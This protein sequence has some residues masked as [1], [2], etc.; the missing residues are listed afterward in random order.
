MQFLWNDPWIL[1]PRLRPSLPKHQ[2]Q[3]FNQSFTIEHLINPVDHT[4]N[5]DLLDTSIHS[6]DMKII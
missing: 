2:N 1:A 4:W 5:E 6:E 3:F